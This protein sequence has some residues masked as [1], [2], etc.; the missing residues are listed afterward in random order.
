MKDYIEYLNNDE[1]PVIISALENLLLSKA[2]E[3]SEKTQENFNKQVNYTLIK[4]SEP[5]VSKLPLDVNEIYKEF[6][7]VSDDFLQKFCESLND[8][9]T[10]K[11]IGDRIITLLNKM[12][13][14]L[15]NIL[16]TNA[17]YNDELYQDAYDEITKSI[18]NKSV[19]ICFI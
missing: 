1:N 16:E 11:Q 6:Y 13:D 19:K 18:E 5:F 12:R 8:N 17:T 4:F 14:Q 3:E 10:S 15:E 7:Q 9:L 2:K